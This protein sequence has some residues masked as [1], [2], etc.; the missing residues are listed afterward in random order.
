MCQI[1]HKFGY[2]YKYFD[3]QST[4]SELVLLFFDRCLS[5]KCYCALLHA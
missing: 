3:M 2:K 5:C 4:D 1:E